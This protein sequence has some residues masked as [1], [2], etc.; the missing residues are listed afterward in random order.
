[1]SRRVVLAIGAREGGGGGG[2]GGGDRSEILKRTPK[3]YLVLWDV[4]LEF[5][6]T[7]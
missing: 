2:G 3:R 5:I 7:P 6:S 4:W 1:M